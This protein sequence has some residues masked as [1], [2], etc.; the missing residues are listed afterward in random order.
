MESGSARA[1]SALAGSALSLGTAH[2]EEG[3]VP[4]ISSVF[5]ISV[6]VPV[7]AFGACVVAAL[8]SGLLVSAPPAAGAAAGPDGPAVRAADWIVSQTRN[9]RIH[10]AEFDFDD[11][12]LTLDSYLAL[13]ASG[14]RP[15]AARKMIATV[16]RNLD[17]YVQVGG[18][19]FA[20]PTAKTLLARRVAGLGRTVGSGSGAVDLRAQLRGMVTANGRVR[21]EGGSDFSSTLTQS[22]AVLAFARTGAAPQPVV[23]YL[24]RQRCPKGFFRESL[25]RKRCR[26]AGS[27]PYVD[28]TAFALQALAAARADGA[29]L[30]GGAVRGTADW[31]VSVQADN[32]GWG[33]LGTPADRN[34][35]T[36]GLSAQALSAVRRSDAIRHS[37]RLAAGWVGNRQITRAVAGGGPAGDDLGAI[38][39]NS[40]DLAAAVEDGIT[41]STRD[42]FRRATAQAEYAFVPVPLGELS[43]VR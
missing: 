35:N 14:A 36:T 10:N 26:V 20:G 22:L 32:G 23:D 27:E 1:V 4:V 24:L 13:V 2:L 31:L 6:R 28:S 40:T 38:A 16:S 5:R 41:R 17:A 25:G 18:D 29:D 33:A 12:G 42:S 7:R 37:Q 19:Y 3:I 11:W 8:A 39:R 15:G 30:P 21:D 43:A 34:T 9:G